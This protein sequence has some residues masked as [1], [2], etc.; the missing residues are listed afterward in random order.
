MRYQ[1]SL[2][3]VRCKRRRTAEQFVPQTAECVE[4]RAVIDVGIA[5]DL[6]GGHVGRAAEC[7]AC[8]R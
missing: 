8:L 1:D 3:R 5:R 6:F 7:R 2:R 4:I